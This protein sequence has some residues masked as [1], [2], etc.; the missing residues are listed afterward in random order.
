MDLVCYGLS[1]TRNPSQHTQ[2][3][4]LRVSPKDAYTTSL[5][6]WVLTSITA[7]KPAGNDQ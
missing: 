2:P 5:I 3:A 4:V 6:S 7:D 1:D